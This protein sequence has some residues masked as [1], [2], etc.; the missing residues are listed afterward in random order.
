MTIEKRYDSTLEEMWQIKRE[1]AAE[2]PSLEAYLRGFLAEQADRER[3]P[4]REVRP[5]RTPPHRTSDG[6]KH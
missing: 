5:L 1:I 2:Y 4:Q 3:R 6:M